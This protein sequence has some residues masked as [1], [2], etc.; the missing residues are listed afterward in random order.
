[1]FGS[2]LVV[3]AL[4]HSEKA[5]PAVPE[6]VDAG[7]VAKDCAAIDGDPDLSPS[8]VRDTFID[9]G[10]TDPVRLLLETTEVRPGESL[11]FAPLNLSGAEISYGLFATVEDAGS[12][13]TLPGTG[14]LVFAIGL[15]AGIGQVGS[16]VSVDVPN[17]APPGD[18]L[19]VL[20]D[21]EGDQFP[22]SDVKAPFTVAGQPRQ[23]PPFMPAGVTTIGDPG[24]TPRYSRR[25]L[26]EAAR[27]IE[28]VLDDEP[29]SSWGIYYRNQKGLGLE[30]SELTM[31]GFD[32]ISRV[33]GMPVRVVIASGPS[34]GE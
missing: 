27:R 33:A 14:G 12:G 34:V 26:N 13:E 6:S 9:Q 23:A 16:C 10:G 25:D 5:G 30:V 22:E 1:M 2:V 20:E 17:S 29:A 4:S 21:V 18:Y 32:E 3:A 11:T 7:R 19:V 31:E 24:G 28:K 8:L 15:R